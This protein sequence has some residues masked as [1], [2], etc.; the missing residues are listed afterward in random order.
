MSELHLVKVL[1]M[2]A[3]CYSQLPFAVDLDKIWLWA[4]GGGLGQ[5]GRESRWAEKQMDLCFSSYPSQPVPFNSQAR[6]EARERDVFITLIDPGA[7]RTVLAHTRLLQTRRWLQLLRIASIWAWKK[8]CSN[9]ITVDWPLE[10]EYPRGL[11]YAR[12]DFKKTKHILES[13]SDVWSNHC[14]LWN[15]N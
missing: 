11:F 1:C 14:H 4:G 10:T 8:V 12:I 13:K 9:T 7:R 2:Q 6:G 15:I 3:I 5:L